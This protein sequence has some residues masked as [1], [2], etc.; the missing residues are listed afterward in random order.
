[1]GAVVEQVAVKGQKIGIIGLSEA[2]E[3]VANSADSLS[4]NEIKE[5]LFDILSSKNYIPE[6]VREDYKEAFFREY[7][8]RILKEDVKEDSLGLEIK[9]LGPGCANC[10]RL[11]KNVMEAVAQLKISASVDHVKDIKEI[12]RYG[13]LGT[14]ALIVNGKVKAVGKVPSVQELITILKGW[15]NQD[16][17]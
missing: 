11:Q 4:E 5:R 3:E 9:I 15:S 14:P 1:M 7:K 16:K 6:K 10:E 8:K 17:V 12:G 2:L 13:I